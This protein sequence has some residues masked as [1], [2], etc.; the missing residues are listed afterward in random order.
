MIETFIPPFLVRFS[1]LFC[2][3]NKKKK[4]HTNDE[5]FG[6]LVS[7]LRMDLF[8]KKSIS[9]ISSKKKTRRRNEMTKVYLY[10]TYKYVDKFCISVYF[11]CNHFNILFICP[12][13]VHCINQLWCEF[14][15]GLKYNLFVIQLDISI[16]F[17]VVLNSFHPGKS[18]NFN[19]IELLSLQKWNN[20]SIR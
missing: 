7:S 14:E 16:E 4:K 3:N 10:S 15:F 5:K 18:S 6:K 19:L 17:F 8:R 20:T 1:E 9:E 11:N 13:V 2:G 12:V